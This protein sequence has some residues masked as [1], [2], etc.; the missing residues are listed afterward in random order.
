MLKCTHV[1]VRSAERRGVLSSRGYMYTARA[2][3]GLL[4]LT[5]VVRALPLYHLS[6]TIHTDCLCLCGGWST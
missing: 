6:D 3:P 5:G 4:K 2:P 1:V